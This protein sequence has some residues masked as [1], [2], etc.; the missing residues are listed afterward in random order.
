MGKTHLMALEPEVAKRLNHF[1]TAFL[2]YHLQGKSEYRDYILGGVCLIV[3][4]GQDTVC[5]RV[6]R[7]HAA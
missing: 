2:G 6:C 3:F 5:L 1:A 4:F 7:S